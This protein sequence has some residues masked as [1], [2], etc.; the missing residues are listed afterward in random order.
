VD[1]TGDSR[2]AFAGEHFLRREHR[3]A[4]DLD[5][6]LHPLR[7]SAGVG[8]HNRNIAGASHTENKLIAALETFDGQRQAT[9]LVFNV[10]I[11]TS[12]VADEVWL[13]LSSME[14]SG[15]HSG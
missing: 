6:V 3:V 8:H 9:E 14:D 5:S 4:V 7:I 11:G 1:R 13:E 12:D 2:L 10:R 15:F